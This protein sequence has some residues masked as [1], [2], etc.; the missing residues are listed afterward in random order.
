MTSLGGKRNRVILQH[1]PYVRAVI[2]RSFLARLLEPD[3]ALSEGYLALVKACESYDSKRGMAVKTWIGN[4]IRW[5]LTNYIKSQKIRQRQGPSGKTMVD[6]PIR[7]SLTD[8][9]INGEMF[10][11]MD[12]RSSIRDDVIA[13]NSQFKLLKHK[14]KVLMRRHYVDG[15]TLKTLAGEEH[16]S[17]Q[18]IRDRFKRALSKIEKAM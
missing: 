9:M 3:D 11:P 6:L 18:A 15:E 7:V 4:Y 10:E 2:R 16:V 12:P 14:T 8:L 13:F 1:M 17:K 5:H